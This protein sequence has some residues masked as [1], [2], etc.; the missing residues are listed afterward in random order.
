MSI[1]LL[2]SQK[3]T[4]CLV[5]YRVNNEFND[6]THT[7]YKATEREEKV[8]KCM[9]IR[10]KK[11]NKA[12]EKTARNKTLLK[13]EVL[14]CENNLEGIARIVIHNIHLSILSHTLDL[15][16][17]T[18]LINLL[19]MIS[20]VIFFMATPTAYGNS[21]VKDWIQA[22]AAT[23]LTLQQHQ[24]LLPAVLSQGS[25]PRLCSYLSP[26]SWILNTLCICAS[27][28]SSASLLGIMSTW[29]YTLQWSSI[30]FVTEC[31]HMRNFPENCLRNMRVEF[32]VQ[33]VKDLVSL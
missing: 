13:V 25:N 20:L 7:V 11:R 26:C 16:L 32:H 18:Q 30:K 19:F 14:I 28:I 23:Y 2:F 9:N 15:H 33:W 31:V 29:H 22:T 21:W 17:E 24:I 5:T 1:P 12:R 8:V 3:M 27:G 6:C 10:D 4:L